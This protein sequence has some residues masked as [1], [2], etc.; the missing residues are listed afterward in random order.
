M[1]GTTRLRRLAAGSGY[2]EEIVEKVLYLE[3]ILTRLA[4]HPDLESAWAL[5]GGTALNL[6]L[7]DVP[8]LSVDIDIDYVGQA[9]RDAM[10][11]ARPAFE[12]AVVAC[13]ERERCAVRRVPSEHAGGKFRL[14]YTAAAGGTGTLEVDINYLWRRPL[15]PLERR[16][17]RFPPD[18]GNEA[19]P[20]LGADPERIAL[21]LNE[22]CTAAIERLLAWTDRER[23]FLD[24]LCDEGEIVAELITD[25]PAT[26]ALVRDQPLLQW[27]AQNVKA[28]RRRER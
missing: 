19:I 9:D 23:E 12:A 16:P 5:K 6:F 2:R 27:K 25:E 18:A 22:I 24:R 20:L 3:A 4:N 13:C 1:I 26:Q 28:R 15:L 7:L 14:R 17:P 10:L 11:A 21:R 8:R